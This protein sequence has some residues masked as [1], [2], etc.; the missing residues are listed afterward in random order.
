MKVSQKPPFRTCCMIAFGGNDMHLDKES[1]TPLYLQ[2]YLRIRDDIEQGTYPC[3]AKLPSI[4]SMA[5]NLQCS[6]NT[7]EAAYT[8]LV[9][10]GFVASRPGSGYV[11]QDVGMLEVGTQRTE[12]ALIG[13]TA[14]GA[15]YDFTYGNLEAGTFPALLWRTIADEVL[16]G[17]ASSA[18]NT[19][20]DPLGEKDLRAEIAWRLATQRDVNCTPD[21]V[22]IQSGTQSSVQNL[23]CLFDHERDVV[24]MEEPGYDG[25]RTTFERSGFRVVPC[26]VVPGLANSDGRKL[27]FEDLEQ[28]RPRLVY[29]TP[30]SQ[31]PTC[32]VMPAVMRERLIA[33]AD[34]TDAY[35]L[36]DDYCRDFRYRERPIPP[37]QSFDRNNRVIYMGTFSKSLS[38]AL[39]M[40]Y[41][42]LPPNL[43]KRW[44]E[45]FSEAYPTVPWLSQEVL[46]RF[47]AS[48]HWERHVRRM[49]VRNRRKFETLIS[50]L[51]RYLGGR[52]EVLENGTGLHLLVAV[53]DGRD[54]D[55]LIR[56]A[57]ERDVAVYGTKKYWM[58]PAKSRRGCILIGFSAIAEKDIEPGIKELARAWF[59]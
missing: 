52:V 28:H 43:M 14:D 53:N 26:R 4:R 21:E 48:D 24:A 12:E 50:A 44:R 36:E 59:D 10:E 16:M 32:A 31:F 42:V 56:A 51:D 19:Y 49:Q 55:E 1:A 35:I 29:V 3:G 9:K 54:E 8:H 46:A 39:R 15:R 17:A 34:E 45:A 22:V 37:L 38:P 25:V 6:R 58:D 47:M 30:S 20:T 40:N 18:C 11:V 23:L 57:A 33:W 2:M 5:E 7:V 41:L 13:T 27:F